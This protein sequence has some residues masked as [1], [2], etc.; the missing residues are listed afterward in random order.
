[1]AVTGVG[2]E[3]VKETSSVFAGLLVLVIPR[4]HL[5]VSNCLATRRGHDCRWRLEE[6]WPKNLCQDWLNTS[7]PIYLFPW[8]TCHCLKCRRRRVNIL[9]NG[10]LQAVHWGILS[11]GFCC[12]ERRGMVAVP[13]SGDSGWHRLLVVEKVP[14]RY[15][16]VCV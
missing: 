11:P 8:C 16:C 5:R 9:D 3:G 7:L 14:P 13:K 1:M 4:C 15:S 12:T 6:I 2:E 10:Q